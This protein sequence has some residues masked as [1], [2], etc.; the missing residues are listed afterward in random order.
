MNAESRPGKIDALAHVADPVQAGP[1]LAAAGVLLRVAVLQ[2]DR[3]AIVQVNVSAFSLHDRLRR[4][5]VLKLLQ[6]AFSG[7]EAEAMVCVADM[8]R[9]YS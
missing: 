4:V 8:A 5:R 6:L 3:V 7:Q 9:D 1:C 2:R